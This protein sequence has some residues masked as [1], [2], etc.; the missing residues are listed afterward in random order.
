MTHNASESPQM[1]S[2]Y[3]A[4]LAVDLTCEAC[5]KKARQALSSVSGI[6]SVHVDVPAKRV[7]V[8]GHAPPSRLL[9]ALRSTGLRTALQGQGRESGVCMFEDVGVARLIPYS[10]TS[11]CV[12]VSVDATR[13]TPGRYQLKVNEYGDLTQADLGPT[14][15]RFSEGGV[16]DVPSLST[17]CV[18]V[19]VSL[20]SCIGRSMCLVN[21]DVPHKTICGIIARSAGAFQNTKS[22]CTC[23]G[24]TIWEENAVIENYTATYGEGK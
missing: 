17:C 20:A 1:S 24:K 13:L 16:L 19:P 10:L 12:D 3:T 15:M 7:V 23:S 8:Q 11:L 18:E 9:Q 5:E 4:E 22:I 2:S 6:D 21:L 14:W